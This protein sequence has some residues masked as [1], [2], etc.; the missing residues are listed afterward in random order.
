[1]SKYWNSLSG[2]KATNTSYYQ[3]R[4]YWVCSIRGRIIQWIFDGWVEVYRLWIMLWKVISYVFSL[5]I[6]LDMSLFNTNHIVHIQNTLRHVFQEQMCN[7]QYL[8]I[9]A[10]VINILKQW[11]DAMRTWNIRA[12]PSKLIAR[13]AEE[14]DRPGYS[15][16]VQ[17]VQRCQLFSVALWNYSEFEVE[18]LQFHRNSP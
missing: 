14:L 2:S 11:N 10:W 1:M 5:I 6:I 3:Y 16:N 8:N 12:R 4:H 9:I 17:C 18:I 13:L 7:K 15:S